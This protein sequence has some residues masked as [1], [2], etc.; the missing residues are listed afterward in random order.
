MKKDADLRAR[1]RDLRLDWKLAGDAVNAKRPFEE[2]KWSGRPFNLFIQD[3]L[4]TILDPPLKVKLF[5]IYYGS[6]WKYS[7]PLFLAKWF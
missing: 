3:R 2:N 6:V 5:Y 1:E 4:S 7:A